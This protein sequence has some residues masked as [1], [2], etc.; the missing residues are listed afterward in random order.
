MDKRDKE[1][2]QGRILAGEQLSGPGGAFAFEHPGAGLYR[3]RRRFAPGRGRG[4]LDFGIVADAPQLPRR[5]PGTE[6]GPIPLHRDVDKTWV[7]LTA[8]RPRLRETTSDAG[9]CAYGSSRC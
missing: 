4:E 2:V 6:V 9:F 8:A 5:I 7:R 3:R 1:A